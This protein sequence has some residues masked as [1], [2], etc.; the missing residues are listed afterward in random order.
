VTGEITVLSAAGAGTD[1][2][3][4]DTIQYIVPIAPVVTNVSVVD[5]DADPFPE[6]KVDRNIANAET[7]I[8]RWNATD[9]VALPANPINI[10]YR[11]NGTSWQE[12][13]GGAN[14]LNGVNGACT[15]GG[16]HT[17]C[18][19]TTSPSSDFFQIRVQVEDAGS[20]L[21]SSTSQFVNSFQMD[22]V[23]GN[24]DSGIGTSAYSAMM[25]TYTS[26]LAR[27]SE[28]VITRDGTIYMNHHK[29]GI[30]KIDPN[31]RNFETYIP[32]TGSSTG[33]A[34]PATSATVNLVYSITLDA[35]DRLLLYDYDRIR[36]V[37]LDGTINTVVGGGATKASGTAALSFEIESYGSDFGKQSLAITAA[38]NG[39]I[40]FAHRESSDATQ[41]RNTWMYDESDG[42][43][44]EITKSGTGWGANAVDDVATQVT[45]S[46]SYTYPK[47]WLDLSDSSVKA[48]FARCQ[49]TNGGSGS[50][51][52]ELNSAGV[53][54]GN[55]DTVTYDN[56][57]CFRNAT[58][59][60]RDGSFYLW[61]ESRIWKLNA[62]GDNFDRIAGDGGSRGVTPDGN[63]A[64]TSSVN[65]HSVWVDEAGT[66]FFTERG[67]IRFID[68]SGNLQ[69]L[70]GQGYFYGDGQVATN[71]RFGRIE[72]FG[73]WNDA[74]TDKIIVRDETVSRIREFAFEGN[75]DTIA[76]SGSF[77]DTT[78][79]IDATTTNM[80]TAGYVDNSITINP[81]N[82]EVYKLNASPYQIMRLERGATN[83]WRTFVTGGTRYSNGAADGTSTIEFPWGGSL[84]GFDPENGKV[85][86]QFTESYYVNY[87]WKAYDTTTGNQEHVAGII[88]PTGVDPGYGVNMTA[89][90]FIPSAYFLYKERPLEATRDTVNDRWIVNTQ[91]GNLFKKMTAASI[92]D[93]Y[94]ATSDTVGSFYYDFNNDK[95]YYSGYNSK[96]IYIRDNPEGAGVEVTL[97]KYA[98][99]I[100]VLGDDMG[101]GINSRSLYMIGQNAEG[102]TG[103]YKY[104]VNPATV[105]L[106]TAVEADGSYGQGQT[107]N[108]QVQFN[109]DVVVD[110][111]GGTPY[112]TLETG[113]TDRNATYV[114][115][116]ET[117]T[118]TFQY[119]IQAGDSTTDLDYV[120]TT[121]LNVNGGSIKDAYGIDV[122]TTL[123]TPGASGSLGDS[124][125]ISISNTILAY[126]RENC[127]AVPNPTPC[128]E[129]LYDAIDDSQVAANLITDTALTGKDLVTQQAKLFI[130]IQGQW[131]AM[132]TNAITVSGWAADSDYNLTIRTEGEARHDGTIYGNFYKL[133]SAANDEPLDIGTNNDRTDMQ[134]T[135]VDGLIIT[136]PAGD[137]AD[138]LE[139]HGDNSIVENNIFYELSDGTIDNCAIKS[140]SPEINIT[141]RNNIAYGQ[142]INDF[143]RMNPSVPNAGNHNWK[144]YNNTV[145]GIQD[146][147]IST[148]SG[149]SYSN[150][151]MDIRNNVVH[152]LPGGVI[153]DL[154]G[155]NVPT[156]AATSTN[157]II[158]NNEAIG[159]SALQNANFTDVVPANGTANDVLFYNT[160]YGQE[161]LKLITEN[162]NDAYNGGA[163]IA[164]VTQDAEGDT[165]PF[166]ANMDVGADEINTTFKTTYMRW[167][168]ASPHSGGLSVNSR[169]EV[170]TDAALTA[171]SIQYYSDAIC[172]T[173]QGAPI[174]LGAAITTHNFV[175]PSNGNY[176]YK[177]T[178][179]ISGVD[180]VSSC[181]RPM[182]IIDDVVAYVR[183]DCV[184]VPNP[185]PCYESLGAAI[186]D[187]NVAA[188]IIAD[189][190]LTGKDLVADAANLIINIDGDWTAADTTNDIDISGWTTSR[191]NK[192]TIRAIGT[193]RTDG[194]VLGNFY[195]LQP[196]PATNGAIEIRSDYITLDGF[197]IDGTNAT[198]TASAEAIRIAADE[199]IIQNMVIHGFEAGDQMDGIYIGGTD[200]GSNTETLI[201]NNIIYNI[202]RQ[203]INLQG[204]A[205]E[206]LTGAMVRVYSNTVYNARSNPQNANSRGVGFYDGNSGCIDPS[207][208]L[209]MR[210]NFVHV[211]SGIAT[212]L[213]TCA[214]F[215]GTMSVNS[216][217]NFFSDSS[218]S[219]LGIGTDNVV[220]RDDIPGSGAG[221][222]FIVNNLGV[223]TENLLLYNDAFNDGLGG[224]TINTF[225]ATDIQSEPRP[226]GTTDIGA[227]EAN[228]NARAVNVSWVE[229]SPHYGGMLVNATWTKA[230]SGAA[231]DQVIQYYADATCT[232]TSGAPISLGTVVNTHAFT[233]PTFGTYTYKLTTVIGGTNY[234]STCSDPMEI[235]SNNLV[236]KIRENCG[237]LTAPD[238][239]TS[240][241][242]WHTN[243]V[244]DHPAL[245]DKDLVAADKSIQVEIDQTW[246][247]P[248]DDRL[249]L[250]GW[251]TD[252]TRR[253]SIIANA[254]AR[255]N[256]TTEGQHFILDPST[257]GHAIQIGTSG[258]VAD[259]QFTYIDGFIIRGVEGASAEGIRVH[260][261]WTSINAMIIHDLEDN[262][263]QDA[264]QIRSANINVEVTNS[265]IYN[266]ARQCIG[267]Q[268]SEAANTTI[269]IDS[270]TAYNCSLQGS[271][272]DHLPA[273]G[274]MGGAAV[275]SANGQI[276]NI[277]NTI[278]H[279]PTTGESAFKMQLGSAYGTVSNNISNDITAPGAASYTNANMTDIVPAGDPGGQNV[280]FES[281]EYGRERFY[282][283]N[284]AWNDAQ[285][286]GVTTVYTV[287]AT[288]QSRPVGANFDIGAVEYRSDMQP[289]V[290]TW[291]QS[292]PYRVDLSVDATWEKATS[293]SLTDQSIQYYSD[294]NCSVASG[295]PIALGAA[296]ETHNFNAPATGVYTYQI[297][298]IIGGTG[299]V[300]ACSLPLN[301]VDTVVAYVRDDCTA[302]PNPAPCYESVAL[303][304]D[305]TVGTVVADTTLTSKDLSAQNKSLLVQIEGEWLAPD[306]SHSV[307]SGWT[308]DEYHNITIKTVGEA[309]HLGNTRG[310]HYKVRP[311][312][313]AH[314]FVTGVSG[315][316]LDTQYTVF[317]GLDI[318]YITGGSNEGIRVNA[319]NMT[320]RNMLIHDFTSTDSDAIHVAE[321]NITLTVENSIFWDLGRS[322]VLLQEHASNVVI[323]IYNCTAYS[324][325]ST[326]AGRPMFGADSN[327]SVAGSIFNMKNNISYI[328]NT[329]GRVDFSV[330]G[331]GGSDALCIACSNNISSDATAPGAG[332]IINANFTDITPAVGT[333]TDVIF[334]DMEI[335]DPD[336]RLRNHA[337][338]DAL[339]VGANIGTIKTDIQG[340]ARPFGANFDIGADEVSNIIRA[341][342]L[343]WV[344]ASPQNTLSVNSSWDV[345]TN[346][347]LTAQSIQ[348][349]ADRTCNTKSG[350]PI[351]LGPAATTHAFTAPADGS[352]TY[353]IT[354]TISG[355]DHYSV[356]SQPIAVSSFVQLIADSPAINEQFGKR[357]DIEGEFL[358]TSAQ[359]IDANY[360]FEYDGSRWNQV[361]RFLGADATPVGSTGYGYDAQLSNEWMFVSD[362]YKVVNGAGTTGVIYVYRNDGANWSF[363]E[364]L[365]RT[366][367]DTIK[368]GN[369]LLDKAGSV[370]GE[371]LVAGCRACVTG[372]P[373][374][375]PLTE[376][377]AVYIHR[378]DGSNWVR[379]TEITSPHADPYYFGESAHV[380]GNVI[381]VGERPRGDIHI[382]RHNGTSW[383][384][385]QTIDHATVP[386]L[387]AGGSY[388]R[389]VNVHG[390]WLAVSAPAENTSRGAVGIFKYNGVTWDHH[391]TLVPSDPMDNMQFGDELSLFGNRLVVGAENYDGDVGRAYV[392]EFDGTQAIGSQWV[393]RERLENPTPA[394]G[395][396]FG[397]NIKTSGPWVVM[398]NSSDDDL[399]ALT[400]SGTVVLQDYDLATTPY[401]TSVTSTTPD[402]TYGFGDKINVRLNF[403]EAVTVTNGIPELLLDLGSINRKAVY[404]TGSG[405]S[406]LNFEYTVDSLDA[407]TDLDIYSRKALLP[408]GANIKS[409]TNIEVSYVLPSKTSGNS[410]ADNSD[411]VINSNTIVTKI[412][413]N[414]GA[415]VGP[416]CYTSLS[417]WHTNFV[418]DSSLTDKDLSIQQKRIVVEIDGPWT[419]PD[420]TRFT[421]SGWTTDATYNIHIKAVGEARHQGFADGDH[422]KFDPNTDGHA[423]IVGVF[424]NVADT[425]YTT[426]EG[427]DMRGT[428]GSSA[429]GFR[430]YA[431]NT[432]FDG[433][434]IHDM[435]SDSDWD[436]D[437]DGI[438]AEQG[439]ITL[440]VRNSIFYNIHR[441]AINNNNSV[442]PVTLIVENVTA[443]NTCTRGMT[444]GAYYGLYP[445]IGFMDVGDNT[446]NNLIIKNTV[447]HCKNGTAEDNGPDYLITRGATVDAASTNNYS[448]DGTAPGSNSTI[449]VSF[450]DTI[451]ADDT[452]NDFIVESLVPGQE[453]LLIVNNAFNDGT[454][455]GADLSASFTNDIHGETR[456]VPFSIGA[457]Q[458]NGVNPATELAWAQTS[459]HKGGLSVNSTW[460]PASSGSLT[461]Q[462]IQYY[463]DA[464]C[465]TA[466]GGPVALGAAI[467]T[468]NFVAPS[469]GVYSY[470]VTS[471]VG[472][473]DYDSL[474]SAP[475]YIIQ[476]IMAYVR[477]DCTVQPNPA[478]CYESLALAI[479]DANVAAGLITDT[480]L[481]GKD[482]VADFASL[483]V[484]IQSAWAA[485]DTTAVTVS[486]WTTDKN[487][488]ITI[489]TTGDARHDGTVHGD[490]YELDPAAAGSAIRIGVDGSKTDTQYT[491]ID[492]LIITGVEA[493]YNHGVFT[494]AF[495][496][497]IKNNILYGL[498]DNGH[499]VNGAICVGGNAG[500]TEITAYNNIIYGRMWNQALN[501]EGG[502]NVQ[503]SIIRFYHN[504]VYNVNAQPIRSAG[505]AED[506]TAT[507]LDIRNN[508]LHNY[509]GSAT[510]ALGGATLPDIHPSSG[511]NTKKDATAL[512]TGDLDNTAY[513]DIV[514]GTDPGG[515]NVY[516]TNI[517]L[518]EENLMLAG[519]T[520]DSARN[521]A[522]TIASIT[523]DI[524]GDSRPYSGPE[525][526]AD[527]NNPINGAIHLGW[528]EDSPYSG[529]LSV[530]STWTKSVHGGLTEQTIQY[531][532]DATCTTTSGA[533]IALGTT[534]TTHNFVATVAGVYSYKITSTIAGSDY[535]ST[536]SQEMDLA[537]N[538][539][540]VKIMQNCGAL[541]APDC[542]TSLSAW[543]TNYVADSSLTDKDLATQQ[544]K[545]IVQIDGPWTAPDTTPVTI[546]GWTTDVDYNITIT[547]INEARHNGSVHGNF[548]VLDPSVAGHAI[549]VGTDANID[550][551]H[552]V[553]DS[554]YTTF[555]GFIIT[556]VEGTSNEAFRVGATN[557]VIEN[558][559]I[560]D[561]DNAG[562]DQQDAIHT[563]N[564]GVTLT[565]RNNIFYNIERQVFFAQ[566]H[567]G[568]MTGGVSWENLGS[569]YNLYNNTM[570]NICY[571]TTCASAIG[572]DDYGDQ[573]TSVLNLYNNIID[574]ANSND[575]EGCINNGGG[576]APANE[577]TINADYNTYNTPTYDGSTI[578]TNDVNG[579]V[580]TDVVPA[581]DPGGDNIYFNNLTA[582]AENFTLYYVPYNDALGRGMDASAF[583]TTDI[584]G[585]TRTPPYYD[586]G[587]D[588][589]D[590]VGNATNL[591]WDISQ[592]SASLT[593]VAQ[594]T[595]A[596]DAGLTTQSIT[597][598]NDGSCGSV[599]SG[600][601]VVGLNPTHSVDITP[602]ATYTYK[603]TSTISGQSVDSQCSDPLVVPHIALL[604]EDCTGAPLPNCYQTITAWHTANGG[605]GSKDLVTTE[606]TSH[607]LLIQ[608]EWTN[609]DTITGLDITG[610][611]TDASHTLTIKAEGAARHT[612]T[613]WGNFYRL[614]GDP[615]TTGNALL[616]LSSNYVTLDGF[617]IN[618]KDA[619]GLSYEGIRV[620]AD[621]IMIKNMIVHN[622][623]TDTQQD[624]IYTSSSNIDFTV[625]NTVIFDINRSALLVQSPNAQMQ[626]TNVK[627]YNVFGSG[628][629]ITG[630]TAWPTIGYH[631]AND[632]YGNFNNCEIDIRNTIAIT[633]NTTNAI[634]N[635]Y[636]NA[637]SGSWA[638][639]S[640]HNIV[641]DDGTY[642]PQTF[643][644][645]NAVLRDNV[646]S[647][648]TGKDVIVTDNTSAYKNF[649]L[650][651]SAFN[652]AI[653]GG[654]NIASIIPFDIQ[655]EPTYLPMDVGADQY[656]GFY[657][658]QYSKWNAISPYDEVN[659]VAQWTRATSPL[660]VDQKITYYGNGSCTG[661]PISGPTSL[662]MALNSDAFVGTMNN[663]YS[664]NITT[665]DVNGTEYTAPC[666]LPM[667]LSA[668]RRVIAGDADRL[669]QFG[670]RVQINA[671]RF[672]TT[673]QED[674]DAYI[675]NFDGTNW[676]EDFSDNYVNR[677]GSGTGQFE[678]GY[679]SSIEGEWAAIN[680]YTLENDGLGTGGVNFMYRW[681]GTNWA[682]HSQV[683]RLTAD[684]DNTGG[685]CFSEANSID[686]EWMIYG[687]HQSTSPGDPI[688]GT[689]GGAAFVYRF[690]GSDWVRFQRLDS[691]NVTD[692]NKFGR[693]TAINGNFIVVTAT[694]ED[695]VYVFKFD[696]SSWV[697][698]DTLAPADSGVEASTGRFG[699]RLAIH[700]DV[701]VVNSPLHDGAGTDRGAVV[702]YRYNGTDWTTIAPVILTA[703]DGVDLDEFSDEITVYGNNIVVGAEDFNAGEGKTY[704]YSW[705]GTTWSEAAIISSP[706]GEAGAQFGDNVSLSGNT[707]AIAAPLE[708]TGAGPN[709]GALYIQDVYGTCN[710]LYHQC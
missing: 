76:G 479:D 263:D 7:M 216:T 96:D 161:N 325:F 372:V 451:P 332:S 435:E 205:A 114:S 341:T 162:F 133:Q 50:G 693:Q 128:Y 313:A 488:N 434:L 246:S 177:V 521:G 338:N 230:L 330:A 365:T 368:D 440:T 337:F 105:N 485:A 433:M 274:S 38:P 393:E 281:L 670:K 369:F 59:M 538:Q 179:T 283:R 196:D 643:L 36:R 99:D 406:T 650:R 136:N 227:D 148:K 9:D 32:Y 247:A 66:V 589:Y 462:S 407:T 138:Y 134:Y 594:W 55:A 400:D 327:Y 146:A 710:S 45:C 492:G 557:T 422:Y 314:A 394:A 609:Y 471:T 683:G 354:S 539:M 525:I 280:Y 22:L 286:S 657:R 129:S 208:V 171:Q 67:K 331:N 470:I 82:G 508:I 669:D 626:N 61:C 345:A 613:P 326:F 526:G 401:V 607:V 185:G 446:G 271:G 74:G 610:W 629:H 40:Y 453:R 695:R 541:T 145:Y 556:G 478:P 575:S 164:E 137:G 223:G 41:D 581:N 700:G 95:L 294:A 413:E 460:T 192:I 639:T 390:D 667:S 605:L 709:A 420:T 191:N 184:A 267:V 113:V 634:H 429:E 410:L 489:K 182:A 218:G 543:H 513:T 328:N 356:C 550:P 621:E 75:V 374:T 97:D 190:T 484:E 17:G 536:C 454:D 35:Q 565:V 444:Y 408:N 39:D 560:H 436:G 258:N 118:L 14:L 632:N 699:D 375:D 604:R 353:R 445:A 603:I 378:F 255:H 244:A 54:V 391:Q 514:P 542:Y 672:A 229:P 89:G 687:C 506:Y 109:E 566:A 169:W 43:V 158:H 174:A 552:N 396:L 333:A 346:A 490:F 221:N 340:D 647:V 389:I 531:Y 682:F 141:I 150:S 151:E 63:L 152:L 123:A 334:E 155:S 486:G 295:G 496:S 645:T 217:N 654:T 309:R 395:D 577:A 616:L 241:S 85:L 207:T 624:A 649:M 72:D 308:T 93:F 601:T 520:F 3:D 499:A 456:S 381:V 477:P 181:S 388:G 361:A 130:I 195:R 139:I 144:I 257:A 124:K 655:G 300:S 377:G 347:G 226:F 447:A 273:I 572:T 428:S 47:P 503:N 262:L 4:R 203:A 2:I 708:D 678:F 421:L 156:V 53:S 342:E 600:P 383:L 265:I 291:A 44:Y 588:E 275:G 439:N 679:S 234:I 480:A 204:T 302:V 211:A 502:P 524:Q 515:N 104:K 49:G 159:A 660:A 292:D 684:G 449:N 358:V 491:T 510:I 561:L 540:V 237:A 671:G 254:G 176:S 591:V 282:L 522:S 336:L 590:G 107:I 668:L 272:I 206:P 547:A 60:G 574:C 519:A 121:S 386:G 298:S 287:D 593:Q 689:N 418:A 694:S 240:L 640:S 466:S 87:M 238:C 65:P 631:N 384:L 578:A 559:I 242:S 615:T 27:E 535:P 135:T 11:E 319:T 98:D 652:D 455:G 16:S 441:S 46:M 636:L 317:D 635:S 90:T 293:G 662:T 659:I 19:A 703:S 664:F 476:D 405:T 140:H 424:G 529:G 42:N 79:D 210:D 362:P 549:T 64:T 188:G 511:N 392:F 183:Q 266:I 411:I 707:L 702:V 379:E 516:F 297:I 551:P 116:S 430:V 70:Y 186:D 637:N 343:A 468:H 120:A 403:S 644:T 614:A 696:G 165:R 595:K 583:L 530:N 34:G 387:S 202:G 214:T 571:G 363:H 154:Q 209:D 249:S 653:G 584:Q 397:D 21:A 509:G 532:A 533:P 278:A 507:V 125:D 442:R 691:P 253:I 160:A 596:T 251:T 564:H 432:L 10:F 321:D 306:T 320:I 163:A 705:N 245:T 487:S 597:Y 612:G 15:V 100:D 112:I 56:S 608:D 108:V 450:R 417:S 558:M 115:G 173:T 103:V 279:T 697:L 431:D 404:K 231:T 212:S 339:N 585:E 30:V 259:S 18:F 505:P 409:A 335:T 472:G 546:S 402:A 690:N 567:S 224:A 512:G 648:G 86:G 370:D 555:D 570:Y 414:C 611:T 57:L 28:F 33:D 680:D 127:T 427:I 698:N 157:N 101:Y 677:G 437:Q 110:T 167:N 553:A 360:I 248:L 324:S 548:Y 220:I 5:D 290:L 200:N 646:P 288:A 464:T 554:Q 52:L 122:D 189:T 692:R 180:Y 673:E 425:Q 426:F 350:T 312:A 576:G 373:D 528:V 493:N 382:F 448:T 458:F 329:S 586:L 651:E 457:D 348:Y 315:N 666:S 568:S 399:N 380:H 285:D 638:A 147:F 628:K 235:A 84:F 617:V 364:A 228:F 106:V 8:I 322:A 685:N 475:L 587:A 78:K 175:A 438:Q 142:A 663:T 658:A 686:G 592:G 198:T 349:Y 419:A 504:T 344:E 48:Y 623:M 627:I 277:R 461:A 6:R 498:A 20:V 582:G 102:V 599:F 149:W 323:N 545:I 289:N 398:G 518:G 481:T 367:G 91:S 260:A 351:A 111:T 366:A 688:P 303:A 73:V 92:D 83:Y 310:N 352:Y 706:T 219:T 187:A 569:T 416:D 527:E 483:T 661:A 495:G 270:V 264:I 222:D 69:T 674:G 474:C 68:D 77:G 385:E 172:G 23:A 26:Y 252:N 13:P 80:R 250:S 681:D 307:I 501:I 443:Y 357:V 213:S 88:P 284:V 537:N 619:T 29:A 268:K 459:P 573:S 233:A 544:K 376:G 579:A 676:V 81:N 197:I 517:G 94:T 467:T 598:Y 359:G 622:F 24:A 58:L 452:G 704:V 305:D 126:V 563:R 562:D 415:L 500:N 641:N 642:A 132:E 236:T 296:A 311:A 178:S 633:N 412:R 215:P 630:G 523:T 269:N 304:I 665:V 602:G 534:A 243:F 620:A 117:N 675:F 618:G 119:T 131:T 276:W 318:G 465:T 261:D 423:I 232:T 469:A 316:A 199:T 463:A 166:G 37:E 194:T 193:A 153:F 168:E 62:A 494:N 31:T 497:V 301:I 606:N 656:D 71:A 256:G 473:T 12:L 625:M 170:A 371:V 580:F 25:M 239:Y 225:V 482:L 355:T 201:R 701:I 51:L 143:F 299:Y 1:A